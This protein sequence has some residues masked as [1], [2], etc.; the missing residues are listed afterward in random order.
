MDFKTFYQEYQK[1]LKAQPKESNLVFNSEESEFGDYIVN[2]K[3][4]YYGFDASDCEDSFYQYDAFRNKNC[5]DT[6]YTAECELVH[7]TTDSFQCFNCTQLLSCGQLQNCAYCY[8]CTGCQD[9]FGC[10]NLYQ[11]RFCFFNQ[12]LTEGEYKQKVAEYLATKTPQEIWAEV[13][14]LRQTFPRPP[15]IGLNNENSEY[16]DYIYN[17]QK[18]YYAFDST[19]NVECG[20]VFDS[21]RNKN[22]FDLTYCMGNEMS[23]EVVDTIESFGCAYGRNIEKCTDCVFS[24]MLI[25]CQNCLGCVDLK[26]QSYCILNKQYT[27]EEY[28]KEKQSILSTIDLS[29]LGK[30]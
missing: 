1:L 8:L 27:P 9:C 20:Y 10:V 18:T 21:H 24:Q 29:L 28:E 17:N 26:N 3:K 12:Q 6:A 4:V 16:G 23:Y 13:Q 14:A 11:K 19:K 15:M 7:E 2:C 30:K 25:N 22:S 5:I